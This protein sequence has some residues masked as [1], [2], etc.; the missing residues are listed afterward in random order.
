MR[1]FFQITFIAIAFTSSAWQGIAQS[2][3]LVTKWGEFGSKP[4]Q[5][6]FPTMIATDKSS[7]VYVVDQHNHRIQKFDANGNFILMW[8]N[9]GS[10][11]GELPLWYCSGFERICVRVRHEQ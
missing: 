8:G 11:K 10:S 9:F 7:D 4:G 1:K 5:F 6:K 3:V 2:A